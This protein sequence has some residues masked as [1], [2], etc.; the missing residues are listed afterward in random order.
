MEAAEIARFADCGRAPRLT[1]RVG[2]LRSVVEAHVNAFNARDFD[3]MAQQFDEDIQISV[4][5]GV[6]HGA[7]EVR[8]YMNGVTRA[9][10]G[11]CADL[12]RVVAEGDDTIVVEYG[13]IN[14][15]SDRSDQAWRLDGRVCEIFEI[16]DGR[17]VRVRSYYGPAETDRTGAA[18]V[19]SRA[20]AARIAEERAA[21]RRVAILVTH[22]P[23]PAEVFD[24]VAAEVGKLLPAEDTAILRYEDDE[25]A[26]VVASWGKRAHGIG[27]GTRLTLEGENVAGIVHRT[28]RPARLD[29]YATATGAIGTHLREAGT[30]S[31][32]GCPIVVEGRLWGVMV[33]AQGVAEP[34]PEGTE[35]RIGAFTELVATAMSNAAARD[36]VARLAEEQAALRRVATA[37]ATVS[38]PVQIFAVV[39]EEVARLLNVE[40]TKIYRYEDDATATVVADRGTADFIIPLGTRLALGGVN[41][42]SQVF[43]TGRPARL[44]DFSKATGPIGLRMRKLGSRVAVASP[45]VVDGRLWGCI[46]A[47]TRKARWLPAGTE[48]RVSEFTELVATAISDTEARSELAASRARIVAATDEE[49]RRVVRDL[50]D[51]AQQRLIHTV[52]TLKLARRALEHGDEAALALADEALEHAQQANVELRELAHGI[53]P[54][55]LT[56]GGLRA[57]LNALASRTPVSVK[58]GVSVGRLPAVVEATAYFVVAEALTNLAK[59]ARAGRGEVTA[60]VEEGTLR[61]RVRD[62]GVG[63]ARP[64]GSGLV[65]IADRLAALDGR[66]WVESPPG[67]GTLVAADIPLPGER[68]AS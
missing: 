54:A 66:L 1:V 11:V 24:A 53:L 52:V 67:G 34:L 8:A 27:V 47:A 61:V 4:A 16:R 26:T 22:E 32:V 31:A 40:D 56:N 39:A 62:D 21:L 19:P 57:G 68:A 45:I 18:N 60:T 10:P 38:A 29:D 46:V 30:Q 44:D 48:L 36:D 64:E 28:G 9:F 50:H 41:V 14:T 63:G 6:M 37:A 12:R 33:A 59:H 35:S 58:L 3:A 55:A 2:G 17:I 15:S 25:T 49:R 43:R 7:E 51:G 42:A 20:E 65:G 13:L 23:A 5:A